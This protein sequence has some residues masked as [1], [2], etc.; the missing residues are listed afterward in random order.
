MKME[1]ADTTCK[2]GSVARERVSQTR[3]PKARHVDRP[4][5]TDRVRWST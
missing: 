5:L 1:A 4:Q 2:A 3:Q